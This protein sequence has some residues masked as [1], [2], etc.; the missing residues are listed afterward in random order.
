MALHIDLL[1][2]KIV[3]DVNVHR[4]HF[5]SCFFYDSTNFYTIGRNDR[6]ILHTGNE[7]RKG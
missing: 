3:G 6:A 7:F 2:Y 1:A 5:S 4:G